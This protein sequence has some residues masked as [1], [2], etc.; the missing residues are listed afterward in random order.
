MNLTCPPEYP[1][2]SEIGPFCCWVVGLGEHLCRK[3]A[4][5]REPMSGWTYCSEHAKDVADMFGYDQIDLLTNEGP[6]NASPQSRTG[7][8]PIQDSRPPYHDLALKCF[9]IVH[10]RGDAGSE[11]EFN[12][13]SSAEQTGW[14]RLAAR[15]AHS[16]ITDWVEA[17]NQSGW[18]WLLK[19][20]ELQV[21]RIKCECG[22]FYYVRSDMIPAFTDHWTN[23][24]N[25]DGLWAGPIPHPREP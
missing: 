12:Y 11:Q 19:M 18:W 24:R 21:V 9:R 16:G 10:G 7:E 23:V 8:S 25:I 3:P 2:A 15:M 22:Q 1:H 14:R 6:G 4:T 5:H 20:G 13:R 17:P